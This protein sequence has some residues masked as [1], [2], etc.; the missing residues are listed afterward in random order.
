MVKN[1]PILANILPCGLSAVFYFF[2]VKTMPK[3]RQQK[4]EVLDNLIKSLKNGKGAV[5][6]VFSGLKVQSDRVFRSKLY[7]EGIEYSVVKKTLLKK[8]FRELGY[9]EDKID[10]LK[11]N[12]SLAVSAKDEVAP[13]KVLDSF[14]KDNQ[15]VSFAGGILENQ[16]IA[17]DK[18]KALAKLPGR[19]ELIAK[20]VSAIK[21]P[22]TGFVNVLAGNLRGLINVLKAVQ[23]R[24]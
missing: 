9:P 6:T 10:N 17:A 18:V 15:M 14:I 22:I 8:A 13:A 11:G 4:K 19:D 5:L 23:N 24:Q 20:T 2:K 12:V 3:S 1:Y 16:W 7:E 21:A